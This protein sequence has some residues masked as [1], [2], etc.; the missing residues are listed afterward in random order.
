LSQTFS[1]DSFG[2]IKKSGS[3]TFTPTYSSATNQFTI[4][5]ATITYDGDGNL[6]TDN[7]DNTYT[8]DPNWGRMLS[9]TSGSATVTNTYDALG[10]MVENNAGGTYT[11]FVY[12]PT[13]TKLAKV[14]GTT[15]VKA[16]VALPGGAKA[17]YTPSGLAYYRHSDWLG[18]SRL[19]ST[20][21]T[22]TS[23]FSSTAYAPFG[24]ESPAKF[25]MRQWAY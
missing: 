5:G 9:V 7:L 15:L 11:Q 1:Y 17:V 19:T 18:S 22:P 14:N 24:I 12:G 3:V 8:W 16:F 10:R 23:I 13:G 6:L 20:A 4:S 25:R 2:N 21:P